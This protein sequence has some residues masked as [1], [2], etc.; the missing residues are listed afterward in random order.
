MDCVQFDDKDMPEK[1]HFNYLLK[2]FW[3]SETWK[4]RAGIDAENILEDPE[5]KRVCMG[6]GSESLTGELME[7]MARRL[8]QMHQQ[9]LLYAS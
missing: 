9:K 1:R 8:S 6:A 3:T 5:S 4:C 7:S 2:E